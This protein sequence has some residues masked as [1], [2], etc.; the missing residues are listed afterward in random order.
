MK[1]GI[2]TKHISS[3][4]IILQHLIK[5][6]AFMSSI[7]FRKKFYE[8]NWQIIKLVLVAAPSFLKKLFANPSGEK[9][10]LALRNIPMLYRIAI[11]CMPRHT[12]YSKDSFRTVNRNGI[13]YQLDLSDWVEWNIYFHN[14]VEPRK[15]LY[16]MVKPGKT[17]IDI[18]ANIG[19]TTLNMAKLIG[20]T[21]CVISFE[22]STNTYKKCLR[23]IALNDTLSNRINLHG[24]ALGEKNESAFLQIAE[25]T[26]RGMNFISTSGEKIEIKKL[27]DVLVD[28]K[29]V[30]ID[31]IKMDVEGYELKVLKGAE[32]LIN[33]HHPKLFIEL[34]NDL[35][36]KQGDSS[37]ALLEW[38]TAH[39]YQV[40]EPN[41]P[42]A[43][44][45]HGHFD[46][47]AE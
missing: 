30:K 7:K 36:N 45:L 25:Q 35:L 14:D 16:S 44:L 5:C 39:H 42:E 2:H 18:G 43:E 27:D 1:S 8:L 34:D 38:L 40:T 13:N 29:K 9:I 17:V 6:E 20:S 32:R 10:V 37:F 19:E 22:P 28:E 33:Q 4:D 11:A 46:I 26:N 24:F 12:F 23:N 31:L 41:I 21:G 15:K 3:K 47:I